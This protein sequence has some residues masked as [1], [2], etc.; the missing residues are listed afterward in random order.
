MQLTHSAD[1]DCESRRSA[2]ASYEQA[3]AIKPDKHEAWYNRGAALSNLGRYQDAIASYEQAVAIKPDKHEAW[4]NRGNVLSD[5]GR[6]E[7][8]IASYDKVIEIKPDDYQAWKQRGNALFDLGRYKEAIAS[9]M[10][11]AQILQELDAP[12]A[13]MPYPTWMKSALRFA[14]RGKLETTLLVAV[15]IFLAP[16]YL[17]WLL[18]FIP[19]QLLCN[20]VRHSKNRFRF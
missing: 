13:D 17:V 19:W 7:E 14:Q 2:I 6:K 20:Q 9:R 10:K 16:F 4:N 18:L 3:V 15:V 5:L 8:A 12:L 1:Q 11:A